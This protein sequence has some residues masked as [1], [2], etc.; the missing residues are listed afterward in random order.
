MN[1]SYKLLSIFLDKKPIPEVI[2]DIVYLK[3]I[4][5]ISNYDEEYS[6]FDLNIYQRKIKGMDIL[7]C[8]QYED[9]EKI[10]FFISDCE[11]VIIEMDYF[12]NMHAANSLYMRRL[13]QAMRMITEKYPTV[14]VC[15]GY[16][17]DIVENYAK[18]LEEIYGSIQ[19]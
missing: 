8:S 11:K 1:N 13:L 14:K 4:E 6:L 17:N 12:S 9:F 18:I 2:P 5:T 15:L 3:N 10:C 16:D 19:L 7:S